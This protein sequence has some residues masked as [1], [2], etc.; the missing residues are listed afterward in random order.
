M[1]SRYK[2]AIAPGPGLVFRSGDLL[3]VIL[4]GASAE[5]D[6]LGA[7]LQICREAAGTDADSLTLLTS[8]IGELVSTADPEGFPGFAVVA[9]ASGD[10]VAV[11]HGDIELRA[12]RFDGTRTDLSG[13]AGAAVTTDR[14]GSGIQEISVA[15]RA[16]EGAADLWTDLESGVAR[17]S[18][19]RWLPAGSIAGEDA[20]K[21]EH[22]DSGATVVAEH[23]DPD[24]DDDPDGEGSDL[25]AV[26]AA[27]G[28]DLRLPSADSDVPVP[29]APGSTDAPEFQAISLREVDSDA[30]LAG[31]QPLGI[32]GVVIESGDEDLIVV[33]GIRCARD[34]HNDPRALYCSRCG[35][36]MVHRTHRMVDGVRPPLGVITFDDGATYA[37][38]REMVIG[39]EPGVDEM[40]ANDVAMAVVIVDEEKTVSRAHAHIKLIDWDVFLEDRGSANGTWVR[41][42]PHQPWRK[43]QPEER[44]ALI[45]GMTVKVGDREFVFDQHHIA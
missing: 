25:A 39:R 38:R 20:T 11:L 2:L 18:G 7:F 14:L 33:K 41:S 9:S 4:R 12:Q 17:G 30:A 8:R 19:F 32:D 45:T 15:P 42:A 21:A 29:P 44:V 13:R 3:A 40:V 31:R 43:V 27:T 34:H 16:D 6:A 1:T 24:H 35:I 23:G 5:V 10:A 37:V 26:L 28:G 22:V 36:K